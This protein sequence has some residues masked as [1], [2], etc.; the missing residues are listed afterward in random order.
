MINDIQ[1]IVKNDYCVGCGACGVIDNE[2]KFELNQS[3]GLRLPKLD[4]KE[5]LKANS[6]CPFTNKNQ[7]FSYFKKYKQSLEFDP[8]TGFYK[9]III[10]SIKDSKQRAASTSGGLTSY[11]LKKLIKK[12]L[13]TGVL[14]LAQNKSSSNLD[15]LFEYKISRSIK[16][17]DEARGTKY[18]P[19]NLKDI[20]KLINSDK[21]KLAIV[22]LPCFIRSIR[23]L[24]EKDEKLKNNIRYAISLVCGH[25]KSINYSKYLAYHAKVKPQDLVQDIDYREP[26][27]EGSAHE[28][29]AR[30]KLD[31]NKSLET[32]PI[33]NIYAEN[34]SYGACM[35]KAC[36]F[37]DDV[38]GENAD[39]TIGDAWIPPFDSDSR[40]TNIAII[41]NN[42]IT[43]LLDSQEL[44]IIKSCKISFVVFLAIIVSPKFYWH[45]RK[46]LLNY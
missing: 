38:A 46:R 17:I 1:T 15:D 25:M 19:G 23:L 4:N 30:F 8:L 20:K 12:N 9:E 35:P 40:G 27:E 14:H 41:R 5:Y 31:D 33:K 32:I 43:K 44:N 28:Y 16:E 18:Y 45:G 6:I 36:S 39:I 42:E 34:W 24:C 26:I 22:G 3:K 11:I 13:I 10:S 7:G 2:I 21:E 29:R 37:C